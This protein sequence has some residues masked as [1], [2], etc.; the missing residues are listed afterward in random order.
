[1]A[2]IIIAMKLDMNVHRHTKLWRMAVLRVHPQIAVVLPALNAHLINTASILPDLMLDI[3]V[4]LF[5]LI[6]SYLLKI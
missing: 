2:R 4:C 1:M 6:N 3:A 5:Y